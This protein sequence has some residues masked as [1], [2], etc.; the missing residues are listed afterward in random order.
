MSHQNYSLTL[1]AYDEV[2]T[3]GSV[4]S[5]AGRRGAP[6]LQH[7]TKRR[8]D[9]S[10]RRLRKEVQNPEHQHGRRC[11]RLQLHL[12]RLRQR[13]LGLPLG[14][15]RQEI[16][17]PQR[18]HGRDGHR[19]RRRH[20]HIP[21][22][23]LDL[24]LGP[25]RKENQYKIGEIASPPAPANARYSGL[26]VFRRFWRIHCTPGTANPPFYPIFSPSAVPKVYLLIRAYHQNS[27][28][29]V[30]HGKNQQKLS[31]RTAI[32]PWLGFLKKIGCDSSVLF[33]L[34]RNIFLYQI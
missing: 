18:E 4:K 30:Q 16:Q 26:D 28:L 6:N 10:L 9:L 5:L 20:L 34:L 1:G 8:L 25:Q 17:D 23:R 31:A 24:H 29:S 19:R 22:E 27:Y 13:R 2:F 33:V 15:R 14:R 32:C 21:Q 3:Y 12:L 7:R 11:R